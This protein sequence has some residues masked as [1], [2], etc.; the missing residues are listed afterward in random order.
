M[1]PDQGV[2]GRVKE[3]RKAPRVSEYCDMGFP[4]KKIDIHNTEISDLLPSH[5]RSFY[6]V[7]QLGV[8]I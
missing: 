3:G 7:P 1:R 4:R 2:A 6:P 8:E 5:R